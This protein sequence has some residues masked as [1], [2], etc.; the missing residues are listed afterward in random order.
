MKIEP[1]DKRRY[2]KR[3]YD[4]ALI[5]IR[6]IFDIPNDEYIFD[7]IYDRGNSKI[8]IKTLKDFNEKEGDK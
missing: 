3:E 6:K 2:I 1:S 4:N 8:I 7:L 5:L